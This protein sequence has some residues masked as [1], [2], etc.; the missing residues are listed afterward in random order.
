[1]FVQPDISKLNNVLDQVCHTI[2]APGVIAGVVVN[3]H[4]PIIVANGMGDAALQQKLLPI[5][6]LRVGSLTKTFTAVAILHLVEAGVF[7][8]NDP[9]SQWVPTIP[10][11]NMITVEHLLRHTS[12]LFNYT[13]SQA[14]FAAVQTTPDILK[15]WT[16][17]EL[18]AY[19]TEDNQVFSPGQGWAYSNTNYILLGIILQITTQQSLAHIY[20]QNIFDPLKMTA[21]FLDGE[22]TIPGGFIPGYASNPE[23]PSQFSD[24]T[25]LM[26][27]SAAWSAGGIVSTAKDLLLFNQA[28]FSGQ[29][30]KPTTFTQMKDFI[31]AIDPIYSMVNGYGLGLVSM[32]IGKNK[33]YG[34][35]GNIPG[36]S[37][38]LGYL[39][40]DK[41]YL[42]V[43]MN[44]NY[45]R[46]ENNKVNVEVMAE[47]IVQ[48][49]LSECRDNTR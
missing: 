7:D 44:Q 47:K 26:H 48:V 9:V 19:A 39:P 36:Y 16:P 29:L 8:L 34:H 38:L 13:D 43:L 46:L 37:S 21:T 40:E 20:R 35:I 24:V 4:A 10:Y 41:L 45:T 5:D 25:N 27:V 11:G 23:T 33:V 31:V 28:L 14:F 1:M 30:L 49:V 12:G 17:N 32:E 6:R 42:V 2:H 3:E 18:V 15:I 22:E